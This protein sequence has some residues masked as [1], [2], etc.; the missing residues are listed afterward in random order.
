M[1][2]DK[3]E[4]FLEFIEIKTKKQEELMLKK[5]NS[6][7]RNNLIFK[8]IDEYYNWVNKTIN[9]LGLSN[10]CEETNNIIEYTSY[11]MESYRF[12]IFIKANNDFSTLNIDDNYNMDIGKIKKIY[13]VNIIINDKYVITFSRDYDLITANNKYDYLCMLFLNNKIKFLEEIKKSVI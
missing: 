5:I 1:N 11:N 13:E 10:K 2:K 7:N 8:S 9:K 6:N 4:Q 12:D 3:L